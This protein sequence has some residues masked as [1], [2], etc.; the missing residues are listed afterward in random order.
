MQR[1]KI[2]VGEEY[3]VVRRHTTRARPFK[4]RVLSVEAD[5]ER[6]VTSGY[7]YRTRIEHDGILVEFDEP[8]TTS[9]DNFTKPPTG[10]AG[11]TTTTAVVEARCVIE[12]WATIAERNAKYEASLRETYEKY[13]R[14]ADKVEPVITAVN[15]KLE[16]LGLEEATVKRDTRRGVNHERTLG[17]RWTFNEDEMAKLLG[18]SVKP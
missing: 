17:A 9:Y 5:I 11:D 10:W 3:G 7:S 2:K 6:R 14:I 4:A 12:E 16:E 15:D 8:V 18:V 1:K 13:D